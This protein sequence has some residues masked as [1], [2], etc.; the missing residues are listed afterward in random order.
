MNITSVVIM[1]IEINSFGNQLDK[2]NG[3]TQQIIFII[4]HEVR[5]SVT[6]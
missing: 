4:T 5:N 6:G 3:L 2:K 1:V